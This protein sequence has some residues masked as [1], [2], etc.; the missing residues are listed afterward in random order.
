MNW[1]EQGLNMEIWTGT[2]RCPT[3]SGVL[4]YGYN[5]KGRDDLHLIIY[6]N[7]KRFELWK[8][9]GKKKLETHGRL[10]DMPVL[11]NNL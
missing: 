8:K 9:D 5:L 11:L 2:G 10:E 1:W 6:P 4:K 3:C 7:K